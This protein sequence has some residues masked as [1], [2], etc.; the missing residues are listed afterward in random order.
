MRPDWKG[1][2]K[3]GFVVSMCSR[4][5]LTL[6]AGLASEAGVALAFI[7]SHAL[8]VLAAGLTQSY[9][10]RIQRG[11]GRSAQCPKEPLVRDQ[12]DKALNPAAS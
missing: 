8:A 4:Q 9:C 12:G 7:G 1:H 2:N 10:G 3:Q 6:I 5:K 11:G